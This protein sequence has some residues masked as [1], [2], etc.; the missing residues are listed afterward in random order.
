[1]VTEDTIID[2]FIAWADD[3][4]DGD[5]AEELE[6]ADECTASFISPDKGLILID[7]VPFASWQV[8]PAGEVSFKL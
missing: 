3:H 1:M 7:D 4:I 6:S 5:L 8:S 2:R